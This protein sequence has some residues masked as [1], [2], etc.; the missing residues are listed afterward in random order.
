MSH[1]WKF[2]RTGGID[3]VLL[4]T[5]DDLVSL[6]QLDQELWVALSCPVRGLELDEKTLALVDA[7]GDGRIG[8]PDVIAAIQAQTMYARSVRSTRRNR[9]TEAT[10]PAATSTLPSQRAGVLPDHSTRG[11]MSARCARG[12]Q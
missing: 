10:S 3:Q 5:G 9:A 12:S 11:R 7:D 1:V 4:E 8:V 6:D 2:F